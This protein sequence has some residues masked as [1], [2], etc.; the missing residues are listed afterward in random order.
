MKKWIALL[1]AAVLMLSC[2]A[3]CGDN[4]APANNGNQ[5]SEGNAANV[6]KWFVANA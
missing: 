4:D 2:L 5:G 6:Q 3:G 1:L